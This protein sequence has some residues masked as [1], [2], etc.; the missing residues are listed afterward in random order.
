MRSKDVFRES[1]DEVI[2]DQKL[3]EDVNDVVYGG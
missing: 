3:Q 1:Q 2:F